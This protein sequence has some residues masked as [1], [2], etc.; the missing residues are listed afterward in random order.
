MPIISVRDNL[1]STWKRNE[2]KQ[3]HKR[4]LISDGTYQCF[5]KLATDNFIAIINLPLSKLIVF[6]NQKYIKNNFS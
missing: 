2:K 6:N 4:N 1:N 5:E 3:T